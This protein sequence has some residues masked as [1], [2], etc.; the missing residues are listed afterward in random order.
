VIDAIVVVVVEI[1]V[2]ARATNQAILLS[3]VASYVTS[4]V[5]HEAAVRTV[6]A[7]LLANR[8]LALAQESRLVACDLSRVNAAPDTLAITATATTLRQR[9]AR[10]AQ[11]HTYRAQKENPFHLYNPF[12]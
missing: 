2:V 10:H 7:A 12:L 9:H 4:L 5:T 1:V 8:L 6:I 11:K 3:L